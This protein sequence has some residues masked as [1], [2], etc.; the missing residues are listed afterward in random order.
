MSYYKNDSEIQE[1]KDIEVDKLYKLSQKVEYAPVIKLRSITN[2][3]MEYAS[4]K[5]SRIFYSR[6]DNFFDSAIAEI[7][8][9]TNGHNKVDLSISSKYHYPGDSYLYQGEYFA[10]LLLEKRKYL[11]DKV[12]DYITKQLADPAFYQGVKKDGDTYPLSQRV[13]D[14]PIKYRELNYLFR[15]G[16]QTKNNNIFNYIYE[17]VITN[18]NKYSEFFSYRKAP[19][20]NFEYFLSYYKKVQKSTADT[21]IKNIDVL[22]YN[23]KFI[24][25]FAKTNALSKEHAKMLSFL[26]QDKKL[27]KKLEENGNSDI[28]HKSKQEQLESK[29]IYLIA[30]LN[31]NKDLISL[32]L[33]KGYTLNEEEK[34]LSVIHKLNEE[35]P[36]LKHLK[37]E[38][39]N[40]LF[41]KIKNAAANN[42]SVSTLINNLT[43]MEI[44]AL[45]KRQSSFPKNIDAE[46]NIYINE[47]KDVDCLKLY[48][49]NKITEVDWLLLSHSYIN[50]IALQDTNFDF[51]AVSKPILIKSLQH[52]LT[53]SV[54][55]DSTLVNQ[56]KNSPEENILNVVSL[57]SPFQQYDLIKKVF[58]H[59][60]T[61]FVEEKTLFL[62]NINAKIIKNNKTFMNED[63]WLLLATKNLTLFSELDLT[64]R[65]DLVEKAKENTEK[66]VAEFI[67]R[68]AS[69]KN[70][71]SI[72]E[73]EQITDKLYKIYQA[74]PN[75]LS[76]FK[77]KKVFGINNDKLN[78]MTAVFEKKMLS[79][80]MESGV[81]LKNKT[82]NRL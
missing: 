74:D 52:I 63:T 62:D 20:E 5:I 76:K 65:I 31:N 69:E 19:F 32:L 28:Y 25:A 59:K 51:N 34:K 9:I 80:T 56:L 1:L 24:L 36:E 67:T 6:D 44:A 3:D 4:T 11:S 30:L 38:N 73:Y 64:Q 66:L 13:E 42:K 40:L 26:L 16:L 70:V 2:T 77:K 41:N 22:F 55:F 75:M 57:L 61:N 58:Q 49:S 33:Q 45:N 29:N 47:N 39:N 10:Y 82:R 17:D 18:K 12:A 72:V 46:S 68:V 50:I 43:D 48:N 27:I 23:K 7:N 35:M 81:E 79:E 78:V 21:H 15:Y 54:D 53:L 8:R 71:L 60:N 14:K 37:I